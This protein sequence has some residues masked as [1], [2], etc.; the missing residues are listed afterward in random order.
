M[1]AAVLLPHLY[2]QFGF[3][4]RGEASH[5]VTRAATITTHRPLEI[6]HYPRPKG[7]SLPLWRTPC[8][9]PAALLRPR[10][11]IRLSRTLVDACVRADSM[12]APQ[13]EDSHG[14]S[15][16]AGAHVLR[17]WGIARHHAS[18]GRLGFA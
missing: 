12:T 16:G 3:Q 17:L 6:V 10:C 15:C 9:M 14:R 8:D 11:R 7:W 18:P 13:V 5:D 4:A 1:R 2:A